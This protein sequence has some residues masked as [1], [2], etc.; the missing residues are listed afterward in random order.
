VPDI[1]DEPIRGVDVGAKGEIYGLIGDLATEGVGI[2]VIS[3]EFS[4]LLRLC[5]R[6]L[7]MKDHAIVVAFARGEA[8]ETAFP[9]AAG[10]MASE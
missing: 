2:V 4:E 7:V 3:S 8:D 1:C 9:Q 6:I 5:D 10:G